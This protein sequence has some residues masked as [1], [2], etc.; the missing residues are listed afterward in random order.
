MTPTPEQPFSVI[1][2]DGE[3]NEPI[4]RFLRRRLRA[5]PPR[6]RKLLRQRRVTLA[7]D[8]DARVLSFGDRLVGP[9]VL[10]VARPT[11]TKPPPAPNRRILL[12]VLHEEDEFAVIDKPPWLPMQP[13]PYHGTDT[14]QNGLVARYPELAGLGRDRNFG[15]VHRLDRET[16]GV[17]VVARTASCYAA[18]VEQFR[19]RTVAKRYVALVDLREQGLEAAELDQPIDG[20]DAHTVV[21][22][23]ETRGDVGSVVL[24]PSTGRMHQIRIHLASCGTPILRDDRYGHGADDLTARLYLKRLALHAEEFSFDHPTTGER[25]TFRRGL[26]RDLRHAWKRAGWVLAP[27]E[28]AAEEPREDE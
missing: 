2:D 7:R 17:V 25:L 14:M 20:K 15:L 19:E 9:G 6:V 13:G 24:H 12:R 11:G 27:A 3:P 5:D 22:S 1:L 4:E 18:L 10:T 16:S 23:V 26:P 28:G 21:E 8:G